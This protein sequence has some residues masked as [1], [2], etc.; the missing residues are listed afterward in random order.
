[1]PRVPLYQDRAISLESPS[2]KKI[3]LGDGILYRLFY[4]LVTPC[5]VID[6]LESLAEQQKK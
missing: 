6:I 1:M 3:R 4:D 2:G 5:T